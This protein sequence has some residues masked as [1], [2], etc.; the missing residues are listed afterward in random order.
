MLPIVDVAP[1][2]DD[3]ADVSAVALQ[4]AETC[5]EDGFFYISDHN[6][7]GGLI[8][9]LTSLS[10][11]FFASTQVEKE[12]I[13]MQE[14]GPAL[15]GYFSVGAELTSG[16]PDL[17]EGIYFGQEH[18][19]DDPRVLSSTPLFGQN[20]FPAIPGFAETV[21]EYMSQ[22]KRLGDRLMTGIALSLGL[23]ANYFQEGLTQEPTQLFRIFHYPSQSA[24]HD[25]AQ[26]GVGEHTDYGLLTILLQDSVGGLQVKRRDQWIDAPPIPGTLICNIGDMLDRMTQ[27]MYRSTP[28]RVR[29]TQSTSRL[30]FPF[31]YDPD[32]DATIRELPLSQS[33]TGSNFN[34]WDGADLSEFQGTYGQYISRKVAKVFP[35]LVKPQD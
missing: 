20:L 28:H 29:N 6:I 9:R 4:I 34:R 35:N 7:D 33:R 24:T 23:P 32:W 13:S 11:Q 10:K 5:K 25:A 1:L 30:S 15:R 14:A 19:A 2:L 22:V 12:Q 27:G 18:A 3:A 31:F 21:T 8:E 26:W 17:K 16:I